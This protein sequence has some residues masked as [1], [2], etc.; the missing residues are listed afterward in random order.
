MAARR[1]TT[2]IL[3]GEIMDGRPSVDCVVFSHAHEYSVQVAIRKDRMT[4]LYTITT[5]AMQGQ[6]SNYGQLMCKGKTDFG[7]MVFDLSVR[8]N[9]SIDLDVKVVTEK[10]AQDQPIVHVIKVPAK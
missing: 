6:G 2:E 8:Q 5:P 1:N 9:D 7:F 4:P 10:F 3:L